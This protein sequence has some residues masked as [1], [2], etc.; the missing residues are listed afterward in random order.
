[1]DAHLLEPAIAGQLAILYDQIEIG[2]DSDRVGLLDGDSAP[3]QPPGALPGQVRAG[4]GEGPA[5]NGPGLPV[6][7]I[8]TTGHQPLLQR[9]AG[10]ANPTRKQVMDHHPDRTVAD[11]PDIGAEID[12]G[13]D[14]PSLGRLALYSNSGIFDQS[15]QLVDQH[16]SDQG[17]A[18]AEPD[19]LIVLEPLD[20]PG[21]RAQG[22]PDQTRQEQ[23]PRGQKHPPEGLG[24]LWRG[25]RIRVG[26]CRGAS[27]SLT[28]RWSTSSGLWPSIWNSAVRVMRW[29]RQA[30][31]KRLT[32]SG[33]TKSRPSNSALGWAT[34]SRAI[35]AR[36]PAP[37]AMPGQSRVARAMATA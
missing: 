17:A 37:M 31:A 20:Q 33:M 12:R 25:G 29:R 3:P 23:L 28:R 11:V 5:L 35:L 1:M 18:D 22:Q 26:H 14:R 8:S 10:R 32:S 13:V 34:L 21:Q 36:G 30:T 7:F 16:D 24:G 19:R 27:C 2:K 9:Q 4:N 6:Q 15:S